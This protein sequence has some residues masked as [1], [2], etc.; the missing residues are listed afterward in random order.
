MVLVVVMIT[1][2]RSCSE[3]HACFVEDDI[4]LLSIMRNVVVAVVVRPASI[5][6]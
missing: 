1:N 3:A 5:E 6:L 2:V 4:I